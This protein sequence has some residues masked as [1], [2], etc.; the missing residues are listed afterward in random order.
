VRTN[1][2][3]TLAESPDGRRWLPE[4]GSREGLDLDL[5]VRLAVRIALGEADALDGRFLHA[6]DDLA[7]LVGQADHIQREDLYVPRLRR[8]RLS[9]RKGRM[10]A[11]VINLERSPERRAH[12]LAELESARA[13][14][15]IMTGVDGRDLDLSDRSVVDESLYSRSEYPA[16]MAGCALSHLRVYRAFVE[17]GADVALVLEDDVTLPADLGDLADSLAGH[18]A[19]AEVILLNYD[20][21]ETLR[22]GHEGAIGVSQSRSL[23]YPIDVRQLGSSAAYLITREAA[24]RM[25]GLVRPVRVSPDDWWWFYREGALDRVRCVTPLPVLKS[26]RFGSTIGFYG[27]GK[28]LRSQLLAS[29][30]RRQVPGL[31]QLIAYRRRLIFRQMTRT[32]I[33][34]GPFVEKPCRL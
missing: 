10:R 8:L 14:Y 32:E 12:M 1:L 28:G 4:L 5:F 33:V 30:V 3:R 6:L 34:D 9:G 18:M 25:S 19:G 21:R 11:Y 15:E 13:D 7:D 2:T 26:P 24:L 29:L 20:G 16:G 27:F 22:F 31:H 23:A 17:S